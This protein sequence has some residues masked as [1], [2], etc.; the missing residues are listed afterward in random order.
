ML[1]ALA[2]V[3]TTPQTNP[4]GAGVTAV[5]A[6]TGNISGGSIDGQI[7]FSR[8]G[9]LWLWRGDSARRLPLEPGNSVVAN[10]KVR[11]IQ[12]ALSQDGS[13]LV[14]VREDETFSDLWLAAP[15]GSNPRPLTT[16]RGNGTPRS[17]NFI[18]S[19]LW[20]F[21]PVWSPDGTEIAFLSDVGTDDLT[22]RATSPAKF[23]QRPISKGLAVTQG[24]LQ[25]PSWSPQGDLLAAGVF[26]NGKSQIYTLKAASGQATKL[27]DQPDGAYDPAYSPDAKSIAFVS[28]RGN[29]GELWL[30]RADGSGGVLL[31]NQN[32]RYP[33]WSPDGKKLAFLGL[34]DA[35]FEI[36]VLDIAADGTSAAGSPRQ[37]SQNARLDG[38]S[39]FSW[40]R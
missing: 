3:V 33:V 28:K 12:P 15:D 36:F 25:R 34:K 7:I 39:G 31:S 11:L 40:S 32:S 26:E 16:N 27:T 5:P 38:A 30:M 24:G 8:Q 20:T 21:N 14:Y 6:P 10:N 18:S 37:L 9:S 4:S 17:P 29:S 1:A 35:N 19:S 13:R 22:I 23:N 2:I